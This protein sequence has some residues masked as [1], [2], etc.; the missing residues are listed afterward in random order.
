[1]A[2]ATTLLEIHLCPRP[3]KIPT[4]KT[5]TKI[6]TLR[7][8]KGR[9]KEKKKK[10]L[11]IQEKVSKMETRNET[12]KKLSYWKLANKGKKQLKQTYG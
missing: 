1:M 11:S 4:K 7:N 8:K 9:E 10:S 6:S 12:H 5:E 3:Q 2:K